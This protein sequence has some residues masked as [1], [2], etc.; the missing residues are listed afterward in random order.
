MRGLVSN[1]LYERRYGVDTSGRL[2]LDG[3]DAENIYYIG[4]N[5]R[6]LH[7]VLPPDSVSDRDVFIDLGSGK[8]RAVLQAATDYP[9][10]KVIGVELVQELNDIARQNIA[11]TTRRLRCRDIELICADLREYRLPDDVTVIFTNNAVRG[12]TFETVLQGISASLGRNPRPARLVYYNPAEDAAVL[13]TG[14]WRKVRTF[15]SR[16]S[17]WPFGATCVYESAAGRTTGP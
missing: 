2:L 16:G 8:G 9:F 7:R 13:S 3:H 1:L 6:L 11:R 17:Q 4:V 10:A 12:P 15:A 5:W 14:A